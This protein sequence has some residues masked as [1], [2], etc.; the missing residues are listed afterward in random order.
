[1]LDNVLRGLN[2]V[3]LWMLVRLRSAGFSQF[4]ETR[5]TL[6]DVSQSRSRM[7]SLRPGCQFPDGMGLSLSV[8]IGQKV[9]IAP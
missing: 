9:S 3:T 2:P 5:S 7:D 1:M 4:I 6:S 8:L